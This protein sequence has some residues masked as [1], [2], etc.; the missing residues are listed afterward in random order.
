MHKNA[1]ECVWGKTTPLWGENYTYPP[2]FARAEDV[3]EE[4]QRLLHVAGVLLAPLGPDEL[5]LRC[6]LLR[7]HVA[8]LDVGLERRRG[9]AP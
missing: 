5:L 9:G 8:L 6:L 2:V 3:G 1:L 4:G 7:R